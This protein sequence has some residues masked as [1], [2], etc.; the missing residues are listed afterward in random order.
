MGISTRLLRRIGFLALTLIDKEQPGTDD[1]PDYIDH[2][3]GA[4]SLAASVDPH[5]SG[6]GGW[7]CAD[8]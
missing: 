8:A 7:P 5:R 6:T 4:S 3:F 2:L 1:I